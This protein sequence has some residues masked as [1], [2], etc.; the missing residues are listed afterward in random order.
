MEYHRTFQIGQRE[1]MDFYLY[2]ALRHRSLGAVGFC[3][4]GLLICW[5]YSAQAQGSPVSFAISM[6]ITFVAVLAAILGGY[7][8]TIRNK[9]RAAIRQ[10]GRERYP[11]EILINGFGLRCTAS[12][13]EVKVAFEKIREIR[14]TRRAVYIYMTENDAWILPKAQM[15][16]PAAETAKLREIFDMVIESQRLHLRKG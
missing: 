12:G 3:V 8:F 13:R 16:D 1:A 14:E 5:L 11:Q 6:V 15:E 7:Y 2:Q 9:V 4:V 10:R